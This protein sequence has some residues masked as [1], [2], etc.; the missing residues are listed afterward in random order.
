[1]DK[2]KAA[3]ADCD[4]LNESEYSEC[5]SDMVLKEVAKIQDSKSVIASYRD[6]MSDRLRN[7]L[8]ADHT[9]ENSNSTS[10]SLFNYDSGGENLE[11]ANYLDTPHAKIFTID[12]FLTNDECTALAQYHQSEADESLESISTVRYDFDYLLEGGAGPVIRFVHIIMY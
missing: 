1:M 9:I 3:S 7:Y 12:G 8:C 5:V 6:V 10:R 2:I 4:Q 11:V